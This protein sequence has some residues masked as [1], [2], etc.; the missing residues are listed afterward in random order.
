MKPEGWQQTNYNK[1]INNKIKEIR[2][3]R[4]SREEP[5]TLQEWI[6][7]INKAAEDNLSPIS[8]DQRK[9]CIKRDTWKLIV[10]RDN[11]VEEKGNKETEKTKIDELNKRIKKESRKD[12]KQTPDWKSSMKTLP[13]Q[14][15]K[16][17][18]KQ[19]NQ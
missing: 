3:I 17:F 18:G 12:R 10:E 19:S 13:T 11:V 2:E 6:H 9:D 16:D 15:K 1:Q 5:V 8:E 4:E 14:I 7:I